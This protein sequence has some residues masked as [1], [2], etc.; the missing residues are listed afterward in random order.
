MIHFPVRIFIRKV[1]PSVLIHLTEGSLFL[2]YQTVCGYMLYALRK[3]ADLSQSL[4]K[5]RLTLARKSA[6]KI[7]IDIVKTGFL[8]QVDASYEILVSMDPSEALK[9]GFM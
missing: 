8:R 1:Q 2:D 7:D 5:R 9:L 4:L 6:H 3:R